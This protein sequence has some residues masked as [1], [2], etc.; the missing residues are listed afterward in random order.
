VGAFLWERFLEVK[1]LWIEVKFF[2]FWDLLIARQFGTQMY[3]VSGLRT[4]IKL[5]LRACNRALLSSTIP[6]HPV[7]RAIFIHFIGSLSPD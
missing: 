1:N 2:L 3:I 6:L 5:E 4:K 7:I